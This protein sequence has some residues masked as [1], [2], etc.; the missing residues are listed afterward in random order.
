MKKTILFSGKILLLS[1]ILSLSFTN[2]VFSQKKNSNKETSSDAP[3]QKGTNSLGLGVG[4]GLN[5]NYYGDVLTPPSLVLTF[6]H[7]VKDNLGP[8]NLGIGGVFSYKSSRYKYSFG[9]Y[10]ATWRNIIV[11]VR[12]TY[13]LTM[14]VDKNN[15]FDPYAGVT[16]GLRFTIY[17]DTYYNSNPILNDPYN[18]NVAYPVVGAFI[19]AKYYFAKSLGAFAEAGYDISFFRAGLCLKF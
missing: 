3:F 11:G 9:N 8:G 16:A 6:D 17:D 5:Y 4:A 14:L 15:K 18:Y 2:S 7:G 19:G 10:K 13:H 1:V 12:G